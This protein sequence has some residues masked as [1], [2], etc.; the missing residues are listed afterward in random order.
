M[1]PEWVLSWKV[2]S[3]FLAEKLPCMY[4]DLC[5]FVAPISLDVEVM[6]LGGFP[7]LC[8]SRVEIYVGRLHVESASD[9]TFCIGK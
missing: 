7:S 2:I 9:Q 5:Y 8:C 6:P 1:D 4:V 3:V